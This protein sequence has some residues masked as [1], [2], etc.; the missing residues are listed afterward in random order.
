MAERF[1][2]RVRLRPEGKNLVL[3]IEVDQVVSYP[4]PPSRGPSWRDA[5]VE[6]ITMRASSS[7]LLRSLTGAEEGGSNV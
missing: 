2:G 4:Q 1:T 5:T 7:A 6:D 3:Q